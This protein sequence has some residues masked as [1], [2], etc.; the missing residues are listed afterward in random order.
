MSLKNRIHTGISFTV[1]PYIILAKNS[2]NF[3]SY[4]SSKHAFH[5]LDDRMTWFKLRS[6][7]STRTETLIFEASPHFLTARKHK[8]YTYCTRFNFC[9]WTA[10][11]EA[12]CCFYTRFCSVEN[13]TFLTLGETSRIRT[14]TDRTSTA[15]NGPPLML[16]SFK[17]WQCCYFSCLFL[18]ISSSFP[19][20]DWSRDPSNFWCDSD[21]LA[22]SAAN[23]SKSVLWVIYVDTL[24]HQIQYI[25]DE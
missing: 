15:S 14:G 23:A 9:A 24:R 21:K 12:L 19:T 16:D 20:S 18:Y 4:I 8:R 11:H 6:N 3:L 7:L 1:I 5:V 22:L 10:I 17:K 2:Y 25:L 13:H